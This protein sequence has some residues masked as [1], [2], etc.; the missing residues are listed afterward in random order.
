[1]QRRRAECSQFLRSSDA[2]LSSRGAI[3]RLASE[4]VE[5]QPSVVQEYNARLLA[6]RELSPGL[7]DIL[8]EVPAM[9]VNMDKSEIH[10]RNFRPKKFSR[11]ALLA[12]MDEIGGLPTNL[13]GVEGTILMLRSN[14]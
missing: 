3:A 7:G 10:L 12:G 4:F 1:M 6:F 8:Y 5:R 11:M 2:A 14:D 13:I 9:T